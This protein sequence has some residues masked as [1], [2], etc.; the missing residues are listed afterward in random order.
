M[1]ASEFESRAKGKDAKEA[2]QAAREQA[3]YDY[4]HAGYTG[5]IAE[6]HDFTV[7]KPKAGEAPSDCVERFR[8][9]SFEVE[10]AE[11]NPYNDK[12]GPAG[13]IDLG[14]GE[15]LFFGSASS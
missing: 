2:F 4:G 6:K 13:C 12:W 9:E 10:G 14:N 15:F 7:I 8:R 1:G 5:T 11:W 3:Q